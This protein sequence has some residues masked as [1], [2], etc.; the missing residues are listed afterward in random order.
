MKWR[1]VVLNNEF[2]IGK[3]VFCIIEKIIPI[4]L[5]IKISSL[6]SLSILIVENLGNSFSSIL[7]IIFSSSKIL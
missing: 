1:S 5:E 3:I 4:N 2:V 7:L 6:D